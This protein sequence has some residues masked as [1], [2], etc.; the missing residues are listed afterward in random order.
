[1]AMAAWGFFIRQF[2]CSL[3]PQRLLCTDGMRIYVFL[4]CTWDLIIFCLVVQ[5][6]YI[7]QCEETEGMYT[8]V[9][10]VGS[11]PQAHNHSTGNVKGS[12]IPWHRHLKVVGCQPYAPAVFIPR[13][14]LVLI[15][16]GWFDPMVLSDAMEKIP[17]DTTED[18]TRDLPTSS[19]VP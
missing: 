9:S 10:S 5:K 6:V 3:Q 18:R 14:I 16:R 15:W 7:S 11:V 8:E 2:I 17:G 1:M 19:T 13:S 4:L 12:Q